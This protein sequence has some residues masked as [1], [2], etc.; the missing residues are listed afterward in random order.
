MST[1]DRHA[2]AGDRPPPCSIPLA[3]ADLSLGN[4]NWTKGLQAMSDWIWSG[5]LSPVA[6]PNH[7]ARVF[8]HI[9]GIFE[10]QLNYSTSLIFD[11]PSYRNGVQV[12]GFVDRVAKE[13]AINLIA[14]RRRVRYTM[15]HHAV[16]GLH[17]ARKHG[18]SDQQYFEKLLGLLDH[19]GSTRVFTPLERSVLEFADAFCCNPKAYTDAQYSQLREVLRRENAEHYEHRQRRFTQLDAARAAWAMALLEGQ[20]PEAAVQACAKAADEAGREMPDS[21]QELTINAQVVELAFLCLQF[22]ALGD[23]LTALNVPDEE[24]LPGVL[25]DLLPASVRAELERLSAP[26]EDGSRPDNRLTPPPLDPSPPLEAITA[27]RVVV[28]APLLKGR[29]IPLVSYEVQTDIATRDKGVAVAGVQV[30]AWGWNFGNY[31]PGGLVYCLAHHGELARFE[32]PYALPLIFNEDEW[33]NGVET[34]GYVSRRLKELLI[35]KVYRILRPRYGLE[36]H[37]MYLYNTYLDEHGVGRAPRVDFTPEQR[38]N[39]RKLALRRAE[40]AALHVL[41]H[42]KAPADVFSS[43]EK[44][45]LIWTGQVVRAPHSAWQAETGLRDQLRAENERQIQ[46]HLRFLDTSPGMGRQAALRRLE[47]HQLVEMAMLVGHMDGLGRLLTILQL[48]GEEAVQAIEGT[49]GPAGGIVPTPDADGQARFTGYF[50]N[51]PALPD[52]LRWTGISEAVL[53][54]NELMVN[55]EANRTVHQRLSGRQKTV[56]ISAAEAARTGEF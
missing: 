16:L 30:G 2:T 19:A 5:H 54:F 55:P 10:Q 3:D 37:T 49:P 44:A 22:V 8:L 33:R 53:T 4:A 1:T 13:L 14:R 56:R 24:F 50:N 7:L 38:E 47:D 41:E 25:S 35:Q 21:L 39:A 51:R 6:F 29:R 28:E 34:A 18:L 52:V 31:F 26:P 15:T 48:E 20:T 43:L 32:A 36:H 42:E 45:A 17:T 46:A 27:G 40:K 23:V 12:S 11:E 9:P